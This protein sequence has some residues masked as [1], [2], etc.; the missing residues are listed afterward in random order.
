MGKIVL[1]IILVLVLIWFASGQPRIGINASLGRAEHMINEDAWLEI[2]R[3]FNAPVNG[4]KY[5]ALNTLYQVEQ[6]GHVDQVRL[7]SSQNI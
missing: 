3:G 2:P 4:V 5:S 1:I 6:T 7:D